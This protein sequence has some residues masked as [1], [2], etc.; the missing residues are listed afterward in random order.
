MDLVKSFIIIILLCAGVINTKAQ[1][2]LVFTSLDEVYSFAEIHSHTLRNARQQSTLAK[3]RTQAAKLGLVNLHGRIS[4]AL[5]D[6][7]KLGINYIPAE[8]FGGPAGT[9][10]PVSFGQ[11]YES[12]FNIEPQIDLINP[13]S[14]AQVRVAKTNEQLTE[15]NNLLDKKLVFEIISAAY[16]NIRT[17]QRQIEVTIMSLANADTLAGILQH[18]QKE[19]QVRHQDVNAA[20]ANQL[21]VKDKLQQL[22]IQLEQQYNDLK[23]LCDIDPHTPVTIAGRENSAAA[24]QLPPRATGHLL[25]RQREWQTRYQQA[26]LRADKR[27]MYP[28]LNL[29]STFS[30]Q[31]SNNI[32]FFGTNDWFSANYIGLKLSIPLLPQVSKIATVKYDRVN[33]EI[34]RNNWSHSKLQDQ[35]NNQQLELDYRKSAKSYEI[36][37]RVEALRKDS[38][39][40]NFNIY[41]EGLI[42]ATELIN[43]FNEWL[44]SSYNTASAAAAAEY[45][46]SKI[47]I[48]NMIK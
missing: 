8:I 46:K 34:A 25:Q 4:I 16:H 2:A 20:K 6:N 37:V 24:V 40:K 33:L 3:Y 14:M 32:N 47:L 9:F 5:T 28:T 42:S 7:T 1:Q 12:N 18:R 43:S 39:Q 10:R 19:G 48:S 27:W 22:E 41:Q 31:E 35:I 17:S 36:A 15:V 38:Y 23:L 21:T 29:F 45:A 13:Y 30:W 11:Q 26:Q 44:N